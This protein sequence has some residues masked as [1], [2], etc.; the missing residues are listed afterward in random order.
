M[1]NFEGAGAYLG[2]GYELSEGVKGAV[3]IYVPFVSEALGAKPNRKPNPNI[4][5]RR[6]TQRGRL[7]SVPIGGVTT[8][9]ADA[10]SEALFRANQQRIVDTTELV[11]A[12]AYSHVL[13][14]ELPGDPAE[15]LY[16]KTVFAEMYRDDAEPELYSGGK[17]AQMVLTYKEAEY[18]TIAHTL[19]FT[20]LTRVADPVEVSNAAFSGAIY[21]RG[22]PRASMGTVHVQ[23]STSGALDGTAK[24]KVKVGSISTYDGQEYSVVAGEWIKIYDED[25]QP[26][27]PSEH[28]G[29]EILFTAGG[30]LTA[31]PDGSGSGLG[32]EWTIAAPRTVLTP[33]Y[34]DRNVYSGA[35]VIATLNG[36]EYVISQIQVTATTAKTPRIG[37]GSLFVR[38]QQDSGLNAWALKIDR[39]YVDTVFY[40]AMLQE[41]ECAIT[42]KMTGDLLSDTVYRDSHQLVFAACQYS[43]AGTNVANAGAEEESIVLEAVD[44]GTDPIC[45]ETIVNG[46][47]E[48]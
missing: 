3:R 34:S 18:V 1:A 6:A 43:A 23:C 16:R 47:A 42:I 12:K 24:V 37:L 45:E 7:L 33:T 36:V 11:A 19:G 8:S 17:V 5:N 29:L 9:A 40:N 38:E 4:T 26:L 2:I 20:R 44:N 13:R 41:A 15:A 48:I 46:I 10:A 39:G 25:D 30:V 22:I 32:D 21:V 31:D 27:G 28:N 14:S 35:Q